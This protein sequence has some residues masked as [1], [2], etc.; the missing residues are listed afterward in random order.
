VVSSPYGV[1]RLVDDF[2][3][4]TPVQIVDLKGHSLVLELEY[5][6]KSSNDPTGDARRCRS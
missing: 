6:G 4:G 5:N 3:I 2:Q 1:V